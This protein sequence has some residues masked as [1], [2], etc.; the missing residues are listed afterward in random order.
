M[1]RPMTTQELFDKLQDIMKEKGLLPDILDY[2]IATD[3]PVPIRDYDFDLKNN[4]DFGG[5][6]GIYLDFWMEYPED[7]ERHRSG[8]GTFKTLDDSR[9][10][11]RTMAVLLADFI[12]EVYAYIST[13]IDDFTWT[14]VDVRASDGN[15]K[16]LEWCCPCRSM[17]EA[18]KRKDELLEKYLEV[19]VRD[20]ATESDG[21]LAERQR[22]GGRGGTEGKQG[23]AEGKRRRGSAAGKDATGGDMLREGT[24]R[25]WGAV[26]IRP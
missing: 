17:E 26:P 18:L 12:I 7:G 5:S 13:N 10:A 25:G 24:G 16:P 21:V 15:G 11:M 3:R 19:S 2:G 22:R 4:L 9:E 23:G 14:G 6:E 1:E 20:N 8:L